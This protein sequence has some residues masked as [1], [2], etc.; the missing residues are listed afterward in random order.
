MFENVREDIRLGVDWHSLPAIRRVAGRRGEVAAVLVLSP[1]LQVVMIYRLQAWLRR[2]GVPILPNLLRRLT[3]VLAGVSIGDRVIIGPGLLLNHGHVVIDGETSIGREC[4]LG[5][6]V[7]IGLN[8]GGP[9]VAFEGPILEQFVF[10]GTGAKILGRV[11]IGYNARIGANAVVI[12][13]VPDNSTAVGVPAR[14]VPHE[15]Q[16]GPAVKT[17]S[18]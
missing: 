5:P 11:R 7:T 3:M 2:H 15:S 14:I 1:E 10:V 16:F 9:D 13:D 12:T 6:F 18:D 8:T 4:S 17:P